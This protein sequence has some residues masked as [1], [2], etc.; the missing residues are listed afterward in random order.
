MNR[1]TSHPHRVSIQFNLPC[2]ESSA[3]ESQ[4]HTWARLETRASFLF[5]VIL[6]AS[7]YKFALRIT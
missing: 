4:A 5:E 2:I 6:K 3:G 7:L 1:L